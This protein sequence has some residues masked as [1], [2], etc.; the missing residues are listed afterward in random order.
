MTGAR[1]GAGGRANPYGQ[2]GHNPWGARVGSCA[3]REIRGR[4]CVYHAAMAAKKRK[5]AASAGAESPKKPRRKPKIEPGSLGLTALESANGEPP[6]PSRALAQKV[7]SEGGAVLSHYREPL[8]G[9]WV[10]LAALPIERVEPTPYQRELSKAHAEKLVKVIP[11]VGRFLDPIIA[12]PH[13]GGFVTPN[14]MHRLSAMR[15]LGAKAITAL[16]VPEHEVAFRILALNT[17]KAH[18]L[19]D[20]ALEVIR[21]LRALAA[22]PASAARH[23]TEFTLEFEQPALIPLG[24][25]Y[26]QNGR[27]SGGAYMP[28]VSRCEAFRD[29]A[30]PACLALREERAQKLLALDKLV[31]EAVARLK[32]S[33]FAS[34]YLK[35]VVVAR[36]NPLRFMKAKDG[37]PVQAYFDKT[38]ERM[39]EG[40]R[41]FDPSKVKAADI[42]LAAAM[43]GGSDEG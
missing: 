43:G 11:K 8:G 31:N 41:K 34:G 33:G 39:M 35:P 18:N 40:A 32:E 14:G 13:E 17:E 19:R 29:E 20:K 38:L 5:S 37:E 6:G 4:R 22:D 10:L 7:E 36:I 12:V 2:D 3:A 23:E 16:I 24:I 25:C 27:F 26:E 15:S 30:L 1:R 28:V 9:H 21:M 42:A